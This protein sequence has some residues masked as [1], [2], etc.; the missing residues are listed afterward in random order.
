MFQCILIL[1]ASTMVKVRRASQYQEGSLTE[2]GRLRIV[3]LSDLRTIETQVSVEEQSV[4]Y[5]MRLGWRSGP[6]PLT[7][8]LISLHLPQ[9]RLLVRVSRVSRSCV[10]C[11]HGVVYLLVEQIPGITADTRICE[12]ANRRQMRTARQ[13]RDLAAETICPRRSRAVLR[14]VSEILRRKERMS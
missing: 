10:C 13:W 5:G 3:H 8:E 7:G 12:C 6:P 9:S 14:N 2:F 1:L 11:A 4:V